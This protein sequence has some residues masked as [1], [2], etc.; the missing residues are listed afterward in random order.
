MSA[1]R[2]NSLESASEDL[3]P[4]LLGA[5][6]SSCDS[7]TL[8]DSLK[9]KRYHQHYMG[10]KYRQ[11]LYKMHKRIINADNSTHLEALKPVHY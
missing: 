10:L 9:H 8:V 3:F 7:H 5:H 6:F 11:I 4:D 2:V 1:A